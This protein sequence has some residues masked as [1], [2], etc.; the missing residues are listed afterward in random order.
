MDFRFQI[1]PPIGDNPQLQNDYEQLSTDISNFRTEQHETEKQIGDCLGA[2]ADKL[3]LVDLRQTRV[4]LS[5]ESDEIRTEQIGTKRYPDSTTARAFAQSATRG[6]KGFSLQIATLDAYIKILTRVNGYLWSADR[7][8]QREASI[9]DEEMRLAE[10]HV[11]AQFAKD[12]PPNTWQAD[13][14]A[15]RL[16]VLNHPIMAGLRNKQRAIHDRPER[17]MIALNEQ[18]IQNAMAQQFR[19]EG[20]IKRLMQESEHAAKHSVVLAD[21]ETQQAEQAEQRRQ[22]IEKDHA[23]VVATARKRLQLK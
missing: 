13:E 2:Y 4:V 23:D 8:R 5:D 10:Q 21:Q 17:D 20:S 18:S 14:N 11:R 19:A 9:V 6:Q 7:A 22:Q 3:R 1:A 15:L 16:F 12:N